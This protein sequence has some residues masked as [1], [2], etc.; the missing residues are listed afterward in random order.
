VKEA[1]DSKSK[2]NFELFVKVDDL[3]NVYSERNLEQNRATFSRRAV[4]GINTVIPL[5]KVF[6]N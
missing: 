1:E 2:V 6:L 4:F 5:S 3:F